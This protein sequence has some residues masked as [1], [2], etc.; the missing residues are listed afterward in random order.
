MRPVRWIA[1][2]ALSACTTGA[3]GADAAQGRPLYETHCG[4]CHY[5]KLHDRKST[6]IQTLAALKVE[7]VRWAG[8]TGRRFTPAEIDDIA[9]YLNRSHYRLAK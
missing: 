4:G 9:E 7:I 8:Q 1:I 2:A 6:R 5:E 3:L